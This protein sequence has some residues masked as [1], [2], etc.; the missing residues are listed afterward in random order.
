MRWAKVVQGS[1]WGYFDAVEGLEDK[2][3]PEGEYRIRWPNG[4][5][6]EH[7]VKSK[8]YEIGSGRDSIYESYSYFVH[9]VNGFKATIHLRG[10]EVEVADLE[11][12][13]PI[14]EVK[15]M[16]TPVEP[17]SGRVYWSD[18]TTTQL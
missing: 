7:A 9:T 12:R 4:E 8:S 3:L 15:N 11:R 6:S 10:L 14:V 16:V 5:I 18:D 17:L 1:N 13:Y 2:P